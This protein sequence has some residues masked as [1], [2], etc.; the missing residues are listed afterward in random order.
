MRTASLPDEYIDH[1]ERDSQLAA[2][3]LD[4]DS[5]FAVAGEV[6]SGMIGLGQAKLSKSLAE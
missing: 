3:G 5:L 4:A 2:A 1:A 6:V